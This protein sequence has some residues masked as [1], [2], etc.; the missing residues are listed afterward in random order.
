MILIIVATT[1][2]FSALIEDD[3]LLYITNCY[4]SYRLSSVRAIWLV[5]ECFFKRGTEY[6]LKIFI[7]IKYLSNFVEVSIKQTI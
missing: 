5:L 1:A 2:Q 3:R 7:V 4:Y 6:T